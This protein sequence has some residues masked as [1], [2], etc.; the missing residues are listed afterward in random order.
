MEAAFRQKGD[1]AS[2]RASIGAA[3][4]E[5]D[6]FRLVLAASFAAPLLKPLGHRS[7]ALHI[8]GDSGGGKTATLKT[9]LSAWGIRTGCARTSTPPRSGSSTTS[10]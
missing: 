1:Y 6:V 2:W 3:I 10:Q 4:H 5:S 9:A 7:F 8:W